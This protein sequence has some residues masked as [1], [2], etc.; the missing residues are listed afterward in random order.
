MPP[1]SDPTG[2][3]EARAVIDA[4]VAVALDDLDEG[5]LSVEAALHAIATE[6]WKAGRAATVAP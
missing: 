1:T 3:D 5:N 2:G 6:A 4:L